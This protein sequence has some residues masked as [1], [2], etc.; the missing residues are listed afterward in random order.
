MLIYNIDLTF[1]WELRNNGSLEASGYKCDT[2]YLSE[3]GD[4]DVTDYQLGDSQCTSI[5][6]LAYDGNPAN[7]QDYGLA[8]ITPFVSQQ[9]Y[10]G[11][12]R[13]RTNIRDLNLDNNF[14]YTDILLN[15]TA[16]S[17]VLGSP[18]IIEL[19]T[20]LEKVYKI[21]SVP[22]EETLIATL[23]VN[24]IDAPYHGLFLLHGKPPT[25]YEHDAF[26]QNALSSNQT[27][28]IRNTR[29][30]TYYLRI[31]GYGREVQHY[32]VEV[33]VKVARFEILNIHP[34]VAAP[35]GNVTIWFTGTVFSYFLQA[36]VV[37]DTDPTEM[38][39]ATNLYWFSS[40]KVYATFNTSALTAGMYT[41]KLVDSA[42]GAVAQLDS[43]L[44]IMEGIRGQLSVLVMPPRP[45]REGEN[46]MVVVFV[47][48]VGN[49]DILTPLMT[50]RTGG[51]ALL[52]QLEEGSLTGYETELGFIPL[53]TDGPGGILPP[54]ASTQIYFDVVPQS[55]FVGRESFEL[56][57]VQATMEPHTYLDQKYEL[58]PA[59]IPDEVWE[60]IW[61]NFLISVGTTWT[62]LQQRVSE[63]A[64]EFSLVQKKVYSFEQI[65]AY[66][67]QVAYGLL[68]GETTSM[69]ILALSMLCSKCPKYPCKNMDTILY[70]ILQGCLYE[71]I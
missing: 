63:V 60:T 2:V 21:E 10:T 64:T 42:T 6:L 18:T 30:G 20:G 12:V 66:Q 51:N 4:W 24:G 49:T 46:G 23:T 7:D 26:S 48:N 27:A 54:G 15:I 31:D 39:P 53:P 29:I 28:V 43:S 45:L 47:H 3:D 11:I 9:D 35:L 69:H 13:T 58:K 41:V 52:R 37:S 70:M 71:L 36:S 68:T 19:T 8:T 55:G 57:Y 50:L 62:S 14:G 67:L 16:P 33:L 38:Y 22:G 59:G 1:E 32:Q 40:E 34:S 61:Q 44:E 56:S 5:T 17:L 65:L 25:G